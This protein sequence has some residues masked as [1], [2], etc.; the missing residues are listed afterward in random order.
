MTRSGWL[1]V[2]LSAA[3]LTTGVVV[4][5][6][7]AVAQTA[8]ATPG[9]CTLLTPK[10]IQ[11]EIHES[12]KPGAP[13]QYAPEFC[14]YPLQPA[15]DLTRSFSVY[16]DTADQCPAKLFKGRTVIKVGHRRGFYDVT[17]RQSTPKTEIHSPALDVKI[18]ASCVGVHWDLP[19]GPQPSGSRAKAIQQQL[20]HLEQRALKSFT[21]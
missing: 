14:D 19:S 12:V 5:G 10:V 9:P 2:L 21:A 7:P 16:L 13:N 3:V 4:T 1:R 17:S 6:A 15:K 11:K 20:L 8:P 18:G